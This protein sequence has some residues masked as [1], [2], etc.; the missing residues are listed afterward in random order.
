VIAIALSYALFAQEPWAKKDWTQWTKKECKQILEESPWATVHGDGGAQ[1]NHLG[2][3]DS[4]GTRADARIQTTYNIQLRSALPV[5]Q[6]LVRQMLIQNK[7]DTSEDPQKRELLRETSSFLNR[8]Y[9]D[10]I[11]VHVIYGSNIEQ[12]VNEMMVYWQT[13]FPLGTVP[14]DAFLNTPSFKKIPPIK[15]IS[16]KGG[17][18]EFELIFPRTFNGNPVIGPNDK[19]ISVEFEMPSLGTTATVRHGNVTDTSG[20]VTGRRAYAEFNVGKMKQNGILVY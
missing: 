2:A 8:R 19:L 12:Y 16:P 4:S 20:G 5:R 7:F 15:F 9:D 14:Q 10:V 6:A 1:A 17:A 18:P 11:V 13:H 3:A